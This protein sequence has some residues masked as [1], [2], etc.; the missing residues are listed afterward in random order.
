MVTKILFF[1]ARLVTV[2]LMLAGGIAVIILG[3]IGTEKDTLFSLVVSLIGFG[4]ILLSS[5]VNHWI[6]EIQKR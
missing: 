3:F 1:L 2:G 4:I 6:G 5:S